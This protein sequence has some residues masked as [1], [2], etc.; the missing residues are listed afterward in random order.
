MRISKPKSM[1]SIEGREI[2]IDQLVYVRATLVSAPVTN[3]DGTTEVFVR[4]I[5]RSH[6]QP[7]VGGYQ[8]SVLSCSIVTLDEATKAIL[9][10]S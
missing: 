1:V 9:A 5:S 2:G 10:R 6:T 4:P 3:P 8:S 7:G